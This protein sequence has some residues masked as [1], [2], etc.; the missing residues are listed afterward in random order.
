[1]AD[2]HLDPKE[3]IPCPR[4]GNKVQR[5]GMR[6]HERSMHKGMRERIHVCMFESRTKVKTYSI[7]HDWKN[8]VV[9]THLPYLEGRED[10]TNRW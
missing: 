9:S 7:Y 8:H 10:D 2:R 1:M 4:C 5:D 3:K 6:R